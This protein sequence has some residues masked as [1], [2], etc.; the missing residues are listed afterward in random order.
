MEVCSHHWTR[1]A[2]L[3]ELTR[4]VRRTVISEFQIITYYC[5]WSFV[6]GSA[7]AQEPEATVLRLLDVKEHLAL[8]KCCGLSILCVDQC[9]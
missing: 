5:P 1:P 6:I 2:V 9:R 7:W 8:S 4:F 3:D